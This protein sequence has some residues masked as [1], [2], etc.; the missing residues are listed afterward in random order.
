MMPEHM[1]HPDTDIKVGFMFVEIGASNKLNRPF[2]RRNP[3]A[4]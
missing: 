3:Q 1:R 2:Q 4:S